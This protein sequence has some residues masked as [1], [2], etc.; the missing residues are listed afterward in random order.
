VWAG[1]GGD[2]LEVD[3]AALTYAAGSLPFNNANSGVVGAYWL[4]GAAFMQ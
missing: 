3:I 2:Y 1:W 4:I